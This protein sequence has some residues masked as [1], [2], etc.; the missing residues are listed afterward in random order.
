[1]RLSKCLYDLD[2]FL[3]KLEQNNKVA[4]DQKQQQQEKK[5]TSVDGEASTEFEFNNDF[6]KC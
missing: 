1:M 4:N 3:N 2:E 5:T 6:K